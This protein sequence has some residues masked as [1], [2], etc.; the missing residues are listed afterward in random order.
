MG[1]GEACISP[2]QDRKKTVTSSKELV[3]GSSSCPTRQ[4]IRGCDTFSRGAISIKSS[5]TARVITLIS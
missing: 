3:I 4:T 5:V 1:T 2:M